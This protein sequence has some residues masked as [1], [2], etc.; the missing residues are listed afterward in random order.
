MLPMGGPHMTAMLRA[1]PSCSR[2]VRVSEPTCP[3]C[4]RDLDEA[5]RSAPSPRAPAARL[6]RAALFAV[7]AAG[8]VAGSTS[9]PD[10]GSS[11]SAYGANPCPDDACLITYEA[12]VEASADGATEASAE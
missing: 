7:G 3:F 8:W 4:G 12:S 2:H 10:G 9:F 11:G 1:C 6:S 5:F